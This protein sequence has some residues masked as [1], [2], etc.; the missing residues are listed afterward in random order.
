MP[1][2][3]TDERRLLHE[4]LQDYLGTTY[5]FETFRKVQKTPDRF[6]RDNWAEYGRLGWLG[7]AIPED[8]GG[9]G[10]GMTELAILMSACGQGLLQEPLLATAVLGAGAIELAGTDQQKTD[11]LAKVAV[12]D[13]ILAFAHNEPMGGFDRGY[14]RTIAAKTANG[15]RLDGVKSF[16]LH[17]PSAQQIVVTARMGGG[18]GR[19]GLFLVPVSAKGLQ[20]KASPAIDGR[21]GAEIALKGV[22]VSA[23]ARLGAGDAD[24]LPVIEAVLDRGT[25]AVCAEICGALQ[26][27]NAM[28]TDYLKQRKQ[29]GQAL[30]RFQVLQHR[31]VDM[32]IAFEETR[33]VTHA[34]LSAVD[35]GLA[36]APRLIATSKAQAS[37]AAHFVGG[38]GVQL[39]G[40]MGMTDE[41]AVGHYYKRLMLCESQFGDAEW[42]TDRMAAMG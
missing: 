17:A 26:A 11:L 7:T 12:G 2:F 41:L 39:H 9:A 25:L 18:D 13:L 24:A 10:G 20:L 16:V 14:V 21:P 22:E 35:A 4:S 3:G 28:T 42:W 1:A 8:A 36:E 37:R 29:F 40:G 34:A 31:L 38:Q 23:A 15:W 6:G 5:T 33:A 30:A 32:N 19:L 27:V